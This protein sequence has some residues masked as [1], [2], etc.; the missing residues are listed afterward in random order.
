MGTR[1]VSEAYRD[2][3]GGV[4][5]V[6]V[7][8]ASAMVVWTSL[9][10]VAHTSAS[11][12]DGRR[13]RPRPRPVS[14]EETAREVAA[15]LATGRSG[16][17]LPRVEA[18]PIERLDRA[19]AWEELT[20]VL[21]GMDRWLA[22]HDRPPR[23]KAVAAL[24][25]VARRDAGN[26]HTDMV[27]VRT[28]FAAALRHLKRA[29]HVLTTVRHAARRG[30]PDVAWANQVMD[31]LTAVGAR[32]AEDGLLRARNGAVDPRR[33]DLAA[34]ALEEGLDLKARGVYVR[35]FDLFEDGIIVG[36]IPQFDLDLF[37]E[38][39][40][41][42]FDPDTLGFTYAIARNGVLERISPYG[43]TGLARTNDDPP[44]TSQVGTKEINIAS[45]SKPLTAMVL[46]RLLEER[47]ESVDNPIAPW[48]PQTW[49]LGAGIG[50]GLDPQLTFRDL[51]THRS[52][53]NANLN[54]DYEYEDLQAY[55]EAGIDQTDKLTFK[56]QNA[57]F[58]MFRVAIP[59]LRYGANGVNQIAALVPYAPM[60]EV[61]A[62][63]YIQ[64]VRDYAFAPTGFVEGG[65]VPSDSTP[66]YYYPFPTNGASGSPPGDWVSRCGSGGWYLSSDELVGVMAFRRFTNDILSPDAREKMDSGFLGWMDP[67]NG[68]GFGQGLY[69]V[70]RTHGGDLTAMLDACYM[71]FFNGVQVAVLANSAA[72]DSHYLG[73]NSYQC[74]AVKWAFEN[75][76]VAP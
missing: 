8:L 58:A 33:L 4:S 67:A 16:G 22:A 43:F 11:G 10:A 19:T 69:G 2:G 39:L 63:L 45:I 75:A 64:T 61:I 48:L 46:L 23:G 42:V 55:A 28:D 59:Y 36:A 12:S 9:F 56:Y 70:Y 18:P 29:V 7:V 60:A 24:A 44:V 52:G 38:N 1:S 71:E 17:E 37:E 53:L 41:D 47:G 21:D 68:Y 25:Q 5:R 51:L 40:D 65:C 35:A 6:V 27:R 20:V 72:P 50:P 31:R 32:L 34:R 66:T 73:G 57:N 54:T 49:D 26:A 74:T 30:S 15:I 13:D 62:G 3:R 14:I 76:F